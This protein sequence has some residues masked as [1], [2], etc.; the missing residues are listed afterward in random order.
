MQIKN[1]KG[2]KKEKMQIIKQT[3][4]GVKGA[5]G[6]RAG[7]TPWVLREGAEQGQPLLLQGRILHACTSLSCRGT[8]WAGEW[9]WGGCGDGMDVGMDDGLGWDG[10]GMDVGTGWAW[11]WGWDG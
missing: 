9:L 5:G 2:K 4:W 7:A 3:R 8:V 6:S 10:M 11:T 1:K